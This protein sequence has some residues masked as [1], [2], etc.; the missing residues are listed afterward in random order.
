[1]IEK[2]RSGE[3]RGR[4][5]GSSQVSAVY[6]PPAFLSFFFFCFSLSPSSSSFVTLPLLF[7][8][9]VHLLS[10]PE[11]SMSL[12]FFF[13]VSFPFSR[14]ASC[15]GHGRERERDG[16]ITERQ[17]RRWS[18]LHGAGHD[19]ELCLHFRRIRTRGGGGRGQLLSACLGH[20]QLTNFRQGCG[21]CV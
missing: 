1:M 18:F 14:V 4:F 21:E 10:W 13:F 6:R 16:A 19:Y 8:V 17:K 11:F 7:L 5:A 3:R 20:T 12:F 15:W 2:A 9:A